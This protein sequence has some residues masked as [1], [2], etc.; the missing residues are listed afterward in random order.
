MPRLHATSTTTRPV[1]H[2]RRRASARRFTRSSSRRRRRPSS[3]PEPDRHQAERRRRAAAASRASAAT[4][5]VTRRCSASGWAAIAAYRS[6]SSGVVCGGR[7]AE[8]DPDADGLAGRGSA[9]RAGRG[10]GRA[11]AG[12]RGR[13]GPRRRG[14]PPRS[15]PGSAVNRN[16]HTGTA[17]ST[18]T[19]R[20]GRSTRSAAGQALR[21]ASL[22]AAGARPLGHGV[23][24]DAGG[25]AGVERLQRAGH[26]DRDELVAGLRDQAREALA[27]GADH[28]DERAVGEVE[29]GQRD[30]TVGR[31]ADHHAAGL[32]VGL[33]LPGQVDRLRDR[34]AGRGTGRGLP[35]AGG[36]AG[37]TPL[38]DEYAVGAEPGR[39]ADDGAEVAGVGHRVQRDDQRRAPCWPRPRRAG[40]RGGRTRRPAPARPGP[41]GPRRRSS[42]R[43][44]PA[45]PRA[46]RC[47]SRRRSVNTSRRR[48]SRSAPSATYTEVIGQPGPQRLDHGVAAG[49]PLVVAALGR[50][51]TARLGA[52]GLLRLRGLLVRPCGRAGPWP[53]ASGPCPRGRGA[54][55]RRTR[56]WGCPCRSS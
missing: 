54:P 14:W 30:V 31:E 40:R 49:D 2:G 29:V 7:L 36:H 16:G 22:R 9:G 34:D 5:P 38:G 50:S 46:A 15:R 32:L 47:P 3:E 27:L 33:E 39:R 41:G 11:A 53:W 6:A 48:P 45:A 20:P 13:G 19:S 10:R 17:T 1:D 4:S 12:R 25:D 8:L 52:G 35:G 37:G 51:A 18:H 21:R 44:R 26:R 28:D 42:G 55:A 43:A 56:R 23:E 24:R